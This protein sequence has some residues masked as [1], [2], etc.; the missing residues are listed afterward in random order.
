MRSRPLWVYGFNHHGQKIKITKRLNF[1]GKSS[2]DFFGNQILIS[3]IL[4]ANQSKK[5]SKNKSVKSKEIIPFLVPIPS[6]FNRFIY[7]QVQV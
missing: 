2:G 6:T 1:I 5:K 3:Q 7:P 4:T